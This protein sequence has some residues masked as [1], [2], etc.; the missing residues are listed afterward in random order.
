[1]KILKSRIITILLALTMIVSCMSAA[2]AAPA[3]SVKIDALA[4]ASIPSGPRYTSEADT[5]NALGLFMGTNNGYELDRS[6]SRAEAIVLLVR[7]LGKEA[8][9][10]ACTDVNPFKDVASWADRYVA[11]AFAKG[12]TKGTSATE[13]DGDANANTLMFITFV[14]R[15]LGYDDNAGDFTYD[16]SNKKAV[17]I[18][19]IPDGSYTNGTSDC[20]RDD[21]V[22]LCYLAL[23]QQMKTGDITLAAKLVADGAVSKYT[24]R[25][26]ALIPVFTGTVTS[27][28]VACVGDSLTYGMSTKDPTTESYPAVLG[29]LTGG[30]FSFTTERYG[31]SGA[32]VKYDGG[33][34]FAMP[35][36]GTQEYKDSLNTKAD[37][38]VIMLGTN[39]AVWATDQSYFTDSFTKMVNTYI[40]LPQK[41]QVIVMLPPHLFGDSLKG[42][43]DKLA[44]I[45]D[46]EKA[47]AKDLNLDVIDAYTFTQSMTVPKYSTDG[48]H[49]T[50]Y[51]YKLLAEFVYDKL[52]DILA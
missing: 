37:I 46:K 4:S 15:A 32:T 9:A 12:L 48:V 34:S 40:N 21:C 51:G 35:Y 44:S 30:P 41:P 33:T 19:L 24:A 5:L 1:M 20:Y 50:T 52:S 13:F 28:V 22:H 25:E 49:F 45:V 7:L 18:N 17:D 2:A 10:K 26:Y 27:H 39:D 47:V 16:T 43:K 29:T 6:A 31:H 23:T 38:V 36:A 8:E 42:Y 3:S 14:L 11:W